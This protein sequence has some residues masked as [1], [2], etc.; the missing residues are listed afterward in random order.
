MCF[1]MLEGP[2]NLYSPFSTEERDEGTA[3][4]NKDML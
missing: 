3:K 1:Y 2:R 4:A